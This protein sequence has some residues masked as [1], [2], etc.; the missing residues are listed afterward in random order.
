VDINGATVAIFEFPSQT[1]NIGYFFYLPKG[2][3]F[4]YLKKMS[5]EW[6]S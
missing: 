5:Y 1:K 3:N 6:E 4:S 2:A